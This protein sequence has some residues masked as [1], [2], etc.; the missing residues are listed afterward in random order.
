LIR[1]RQREKVLNTLKPGNCTINFPDRRVAEGKWND[2]ELNGFGTFTWPDGER[3]EGSFE[4][5]YRSGQVTYFLNNRN[6]YTGQW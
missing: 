3:Y 5:G 1:A 4:S 2:R 6:V